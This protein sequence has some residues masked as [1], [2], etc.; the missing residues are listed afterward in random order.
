MISLVLLFA[1]LPSGLALN[2]TR[3]L[4]DDVLQ[5]T[6]TTES[7]TP[8]QARR[9][10]D[11]FQDTFLSLDRLRSLDADTAAVLADIKVKY[12]SLNGLTTL[13]PEAARALAKSP[14]THL[15]LGGV[16]A[17][18]VATAGALAEFKGE[19]LYLLGLVSL[20]VRTATA[21][22]A[23]AGGSL[24]LSAFRGLALLDIDAAEQIA[25]SKACFLVLGVTALDVAIARALARFEGE[26]LSI[27]CLKTLD[28]PLAEALGGFGGRWLALDGLV[29]LDPATAKAIA[30]FRGEDLCLDGL[31]TLDTPTAT[32]LAA[33]GGRQLSLSSLTTLD[34]EA[35]AALAKIAGCLYVSEELEW[36]FCNENP[37][38][39]DTVAAW[40]ALTRGNLAGI[41]SLDSPDSIAIARALA[42]RKGPLLMPDLRKISPKTLSALTEKE[43]VEIPLVETLELIPE[44]D[45]S[46]TE[47]F[48]APD[49]LEERQEKQRRQQAAR[50]AE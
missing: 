36:A 47:D 17:L 34:A 24:V 22:A 45:G 16:P 14:A 3:S 19:E 39:L 13:S 30:A 42:A 27:N 15:Y 25:A 38:T 40:V 46:P 18:D 44:P 21:L 26:G 48:I 23:Y 5:D 10:G 7:L 33:F 35:A 50:E 29:G 9:L 28:V 41:T 6:N 43:D 32:A 2:S 1:S 37:L 11:G 4:P 12:L 31:R 49:W 8:E 20:D